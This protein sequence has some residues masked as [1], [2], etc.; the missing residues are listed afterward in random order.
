MVPFL[1]NL[2][3]YFCCVRFVTDVTV[4]WLGSLILWMLPQLVN[5][6]TV[7]GTEG[8]VT[9]GARMA[10]ALDVRLCVATGAKPTDEQVQTHSH[11]EKTTF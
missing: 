11:S 5:S 3:S 2:Y 1:V 8:L 6:Q 9:I 7:P 10:E 4:E